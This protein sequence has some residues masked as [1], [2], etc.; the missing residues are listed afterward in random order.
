MAQK[1]K[2]KGPKGSA[3]ATPFRTPTARAKDRPEVSPSVRLAT[4]E[5]AVAAAADRAVAAARALAASPSA[6]TTRALLLAHFEWRAGCRK[7][8]GGVRQAE[9]AGRGSRTPQAV[10]ERERAWAGEIA[11]LAV[12]TL[13]ALA[14]GEAQD[15]TASS[16]RELLRDL[17]WGRALPEGTLTRVGTLYAGRAGGKLQWTVEPHAAGL[18]PMPLEGGFDQEL[19]RATVLYTVEPRTGRVL[20]VEPVASDTPRRRR[21]TSRP[22]GGAPKSP[23]G[24]TKRAPGRPR[25]G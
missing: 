5:P 11:T 2:R 18:P 22:A 4:L 1:K 8:F 24:R 6:G 3:S 20:A 17:R 15:R 25:K 10:R 12:P 7:L 21:P 16:A 23:R 13:E 9:R 14:A 19:N